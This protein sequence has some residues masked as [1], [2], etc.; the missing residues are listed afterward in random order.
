MFFL[1]DNAKQEYV[2]IINKL[3]EM[4]KPAAG[5]QTETTSSTS[6]QCLKVT[7]DKNVTKIILNRPEKKNALTREVS[8]Y[9]N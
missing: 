9:L 4:E 7:K 5:E 8:Y 6:Y 3:E 1:K 2:S